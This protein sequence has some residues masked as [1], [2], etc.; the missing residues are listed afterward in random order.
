MENNLTL[1]SEF[2]IRGDA[3]EKD[4]RIEIDIFGKERYYLDNC[5]IGEYD[6]VGAGK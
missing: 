5:L 3:E 1:S 6:G 2:P 4:L